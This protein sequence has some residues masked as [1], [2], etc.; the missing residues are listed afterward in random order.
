MA[1]TVTQYANFDPEADCKKLKSAMKGL[2][3]DE[4]AIIAVICYRSNEQR[5]ELK[6]KYKTMYGKDLV[7]EIKGE[8][9]GDFEKV[10]LGLMMTPADFDAYSIKEAVKGL[11]TDEKALVE[12]LCS[13]SN[14]EMQAMKASYKKLY[15][16]EM[17][18]AVASDVSGDF[19]RILVSVITAHREEDGPVDQ[20]KA[21]A[22][23]KALYEAGEKQWGTDE[24]TFNAILCSRSY[25]ALRAIFDEYEK[26][27]KKTMEQAIKGEMSGDIEKACLAIVQCSRDPAGFFSEQL[28]RSMKG[29]GTDE[30][31]LNRIMVSRSEKDMETIKTAFAAKYKKSLYSFI[32]DDTSGDYERSLLAL[33]RD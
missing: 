8:L 20:A 12:I 31:T 6:L 9:S 1:G 2:G 23:A 14:A 29:A 7:D 11:G 5:Q 21:A 22:D 32:K 26:I 18:K 28:Y 33:C 16:K 24:S 13:R 4:K 17:E 19:K 10:I 25:T 3:T 15:K 30:N 27:S